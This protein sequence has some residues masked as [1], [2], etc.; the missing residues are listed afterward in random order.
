MAIKKSTALKLYN[1]YH[2]A[3]PIA[4][5]KTIDTFIEANAA[6]GHEHLELFVCEKK[7]DKIIAALRKRGFVVQ[8]L[9][10]KATNNWRLVGISWTSAEYLK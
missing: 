5:L 8:Y 10:W 9:K 4:D 7:S 6:L 3:M 2:S 1:Q